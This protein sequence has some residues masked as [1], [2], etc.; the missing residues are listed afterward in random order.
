ME[1][2]LQGDCEYFWVSSL[3]RVITRTADRSIHRTHPGFAFSEEMTW[4]Q[5]S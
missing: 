5:N 3:G 2:Y 1:Q 4:A